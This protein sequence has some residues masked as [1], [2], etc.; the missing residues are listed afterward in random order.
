MSY[1]FKI[2][3]ADI[4][5]P[6]VWRRILVPKDIT[7]DVFHQVIQVAFGW[8]DSHLY[9]FSQHGRASERIYQIPDPESDDETVLDSSINRLS[10]TFSIVGQGFTYI[11]DFGDN[12]IH[13]I[14]LEEITEELIIMPL[15]LAGKGACPPEDCG[16]VPGYYYLLKV[17]DNPKHP[18]HKDMKAWLGLKMDEY[19]DIHKFDLE[20]INN[21]FS[22]MQY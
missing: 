9:Q 8:E 10:E 17:L 12:W 22:S 2:Q 18:E 19:F 14:T 6:P 15:C 13:Q 4:Q 20:A 7:F 16:G 1:Q 21:K 3:I 11:Y 5:K